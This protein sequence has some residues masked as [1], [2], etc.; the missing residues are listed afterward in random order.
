MIK[1]SVLDKSPVTS[2]SIAYEALRQTA[3]LAR[4]TE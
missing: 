4:K 3:D 1:L 2:G